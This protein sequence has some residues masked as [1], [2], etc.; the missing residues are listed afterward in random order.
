MRP[1]PISWFVT[2]EGTAKLDDIA[3]DAHINLSY[4]RESKMEWV[5][6]SGTAVISRDRGIIRKLYAS[7]W[8]AW[9]GNEGDPRHGNPDDPR[10]VLIGVDVQMAEFLEINKPKPLVLFEIAKGWVTGSEPDLGEVH[11]LDQAHR[12]G[13]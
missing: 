3:H 9:F 12:P 7:D 10:M 6:V 11:E 4:F 8:K 5:S 1:G 13:R 2:S